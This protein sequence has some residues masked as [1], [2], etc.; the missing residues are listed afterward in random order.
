MKLLKIALL[1]LF[2]T[3]MFAQSSATDAAP[4]ETI[5]I[6]IEATELDRRML[7]EKLNARGQEHKLKF[8]SAD[9]DF[10]YRIVFATDQ[11]TALSN[12][13]SRGGGGSYNTSSASATVYASNGNELFQFKRRLRVTD[14]GSANAVA[15]EII[16]RML[17]L[18]GPA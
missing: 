18:R 7:L 17:K 15:K 12:R 16:K 6:K 9:Q 1:V 4:V 8:E 11:E 13:Y 10:T 2:S 3:S 5:K 14:A